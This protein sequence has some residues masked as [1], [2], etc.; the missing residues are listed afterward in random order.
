[1]RERQ[2]LALAEHVRAHRPR[3]GFPPIVC[4]DFN[5]EPESAEIRYL[6]GLQSLDGSSV[7]FVDAFRDAGEGPGLTWSNRNPYA[8][9]WLE[10]ER[11]IDY[12]FVGP[13]RRPDGLG[14]VLSAR[15]VGDEP[16]AG[17][18]WTDHFGVLAEL[19]TEPVDP[20]A[21]PPA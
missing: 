7:H 21:L 8:R 6:Q 10:P 19:R 15:V 14:M 3:N 5:A 13:P 4:G 16:E 11:R 9:P 12:V 2:V 1:V 17:V 18:W 20:A